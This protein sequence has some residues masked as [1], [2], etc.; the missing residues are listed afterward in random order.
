LRW[1]ILY[2]IIGIIF[3]LFHF[4]F[5]QQ[6]RRLE[7]QQQNRSRLLKYQ[8]ANIQQQLEPHFLFNAINNISH[9]YQE[10]KKEAAYDYVSKMSR[11][12]VSA[13]ENSEKVTIPLEEEL[14]F[15]RN[16]LSLEQ[17]RKGN[18]E[19]EIEVHEKALLNFGVPKMLV[20]NFVENSM[21]H[22]IRHLRNRKG[23]VRIYSLETLT[24]FKVIIDDNG[25][26]RKRSAEFKTH[27]TKK[28]L[29]TLERIL[30]HHEELN[31]SRITFSI[32]DLQDI[33]NQAEGTRVV[34]MIWK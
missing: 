20:Q 8:L 18:F 27:G 17:L 5:R 12:I 3:I 34:I 22:G 28:G 26:G 11:L 24:G 7:I 19:F 32:E 16:Y 23:H 31:N 9:F 33:N 15:V 4:V 14:S 2:A 1:F 10:G 29:K 13:M 25:I 30:A 21:K 6:R